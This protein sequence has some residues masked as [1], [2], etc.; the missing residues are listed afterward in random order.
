M[1]ILRYKFIVIISLAVGAIRSIESL[2]KVII[3]TDAGVDD[4]FAIFLIL[5]DKYTQFKVLAITCSY[6]NTYENNVVTNVR[7]ILTVA[8]RSDIP[9]YKGAKKPLLNEY[10]AASQYG[11]DGFGDFNFTRNITVEA[12]NS[13]HAV[14]ALIDLVKQYPGEITL[15]SLAPLTNIATA[16]AL[17]PDFLKYLKKHII[18]GGSVFGFGNVLPNVEFNFYQDPESN[19]MILN[20]TET[21]VLFP[22]D[23]GL[24][25]AIPLDWRKN[26]LGKLNSTTI[27][28]LNK[29]E[30]SYNMKSSSW[31]ASDAMAAAVLIR[32]ELVEKYIVTNV[33]A[34]VDGSARGSL[35]VDYTNLTSRPNNTKIIDSF[36][37]T[38]YQE[39]LLETFS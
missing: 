1:I 36:N 8:N 25:S 30:Y 15:L 16:V 35:L 6:G 2:E 33:A 38:G 5:R 20:N 39:L 9:I 13:K 24:K 3:N 18:L 10:T 4:A 14:I 11:S 7:K 27:N 19:Y 22:W 21:C 12:D 17:E 31:I 23:T 32:P 37:V 29:A 28:F 26:V 34:V